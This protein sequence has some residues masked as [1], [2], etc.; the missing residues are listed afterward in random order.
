MKMN[1][2]YTLENTASHQSLTALVNRLSADQYNQPL[3]AGWTVGGVLAHL[4]FWDQRALVLLHKWQ[5]EGIS[6]SDVDVDVINEATREMFNALS[7]TAAQQVVLAAAQAVDGEIEAL[8]PEFLAE[9]ETRGKT[10]RLDRSAH[11]YMHLAQIEAA[12]GF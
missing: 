3:E 8:S 12:L 5:Q 1:T 10:V 4:A 2:A 6:P 9:V 11:R 7:P